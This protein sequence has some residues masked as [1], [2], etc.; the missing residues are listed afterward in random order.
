MVLGIK[1]TVQTVPV[2]VFFE[3]LFF[4]QKSAFT[5]RKRTYIS[6]TFIGIH[7]VIEFYAVWQTTRK[8]IMVR[9][10]MILT[11]P[12]LMCIWWFVIFCHKNYDFSDFI[13]FTIFRAVKLKMN[14]YFHGQLT[15]KDSGPTPLAKHPAIF[16][17][18]R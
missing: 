15:T 2:F 4:F 10:I 11:K 16:S 9:E 18:F 12:P 6:L 3:L 1:I 17:N 8:V 13:R 14:C 7:K 5:S